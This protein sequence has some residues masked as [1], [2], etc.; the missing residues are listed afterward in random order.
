[1]EW[2]YDIYQGAKRVQRL[3]SS[4]IRTILDKAAA[5]RAEGFRVIPFS[6]GEPDFNTPED[7]KQATI[8]ALNENYTHYGSNRGLPKL[9]ENIAAMAKEEIGIEYRPE[10]EVYVTSS[11]AEALNNAILSFVD[12][13]DEVII[14]S[15]AFV[16][17]KNLVKFAGG[18][19]IDIPLKKEN[20]FQI[21]LDEVSGKITSRTKMIIIN[22]PNNPTG[23]VYEKKTLARLCKLAVRRNILVLS[24]EMY[25]RLTYGGARFHS[26]ASFPEMK[27]RSIIVNGFS[28]TYAMTGWRLGYILT[29][30]RLGK[31]IIKTHQYSTT[32]SP[33]FLQVGLANAMFSEKTKQETECMIAEFA[34]RRL[35]MLEGIA[36]IPKLS[37]VEPNGAFYIMVDVSQ[38]GLSGE[39]F[40]AKLLEEEKVAAVPAVGLG[41]GCPEFVRFSFAAS[42]EDIEEGLKRL[43][44]FCE[45]L[46]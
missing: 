42:M 16:S 5:L 21:D 25:S 20:H 32:C 37:C 14:F 22:N 39:E 43:A 45:R 28:K 10:D 41:S 4:P 33:T 30:A 7:I 24:D 19:V 29:D 6:A 12:E 44:A 11:G 2:S 26:I 23:A 18:T 8:Q 9:R 35:V 1:M 17:Y 40:A 38:T 3:E 46:S 15:P 27:E 13:G 36:A 31:C 34:K